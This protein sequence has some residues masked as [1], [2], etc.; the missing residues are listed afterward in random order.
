MPPLD[1]RRWVGPV[2]E[3]AYEN[4]DG[5]LVYPEFP[6]ER[7]AS[8][9]DFGCGCGRVARQLIL[10]RSRPKRYVGI[11]LHPELIAWCQ[12]NL[13][14]AA[15][16]FS[17]HHHDVFDRLQNSDPSKPEVL[18]FPVEDASVTLF[19]ALSIFTH[20]TQPQIAFYLGEA[21]RVLAPEGEMNA[22]FLLFEKDEFAVIAHD[23][24]RNALYIDYDY[25]SAAVYYDRSWLQDTFKQAG[26]ALRRIANIPD[27]HGHQF[28]LILGRAADGEAAMA[29]PNAHETDPSPD[30]AARD[31]RSA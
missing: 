25:P 23:A 10:Q 3:A 30:P 12:A 9:F 2:A 17:F 28:R 31:R 6:P 18:P 4:P 27:E 21:A 26:L 5:S 8:V 29:L 11:D 20:I 7:Y 24:Q 1:Y 13:Q 22:T 16:G 14:P 19:E 15:P